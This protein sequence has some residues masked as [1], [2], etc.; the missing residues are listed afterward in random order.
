[1]KVSKPF[2][3]KIRALLGKWQSLLAPKERGR[4]AGAVPSFKNTASAAL[5]N[6]DAN[7]ASGRLITPLLEQEASAQDFYN[8]HIKEERSK[9]LEKAV[10]E[11]KALHDE[12]ETKPGEE[13][14]DAILNSVLTNLV[15]FIKIMTYPF[16]VRFTQLT[17]QED[18]P[19]HKII[20][21]LK[22]VDLLTTAYLHQCKV[23][24]LQLESVASLI[25][26]P[27][28]G[29]DPFRYVSYI[30]I[31]DR[32]N[33]L[34]DYIDWLRKE[35]KKTE[36]E[37]E[38]KTQKKHSNLEVDKDQT[39]GEKQISIQSKYIDRLNNF[40]KPYFDESQHVDLKNVLEGQSLKETLVFAG[41]ANQFTDLFWRSK[42]PE[43]D[44]IDN[45]KRHIERWICENFKHKS[46][47]KISDFDPDSVHKDIARAVKS[48]CNEVVLK[49]RTRNLLNFVSNGQTF[50]SQTKVHCRV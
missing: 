28:K 7:R 12:L 31:N 45:T 24:L 9:S 43:T 34:P 48:R 41:N 16:L 36:N 37:I 10:A 1:M 50:K 29:T 26:N 8:T 30:K 15:D 40:L 33:V 3:D 27:G 19:R 25:K 20:I 6:N 49:I 32:I 5:Q 2:V 4:S 22:E 11:T 35:I 18:Y 39:R 23:F 21:F 44:I 38:N 46:G 47:I 13:G 42:R 14:D 17:I